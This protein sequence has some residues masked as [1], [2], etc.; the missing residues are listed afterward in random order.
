MWEMKY[1]APNG[2]IDFMWYGSN[3]TRE[4]AEQR[5]RSMPDIGLEP[6][7]F[8]KI[9]QL[10]TD[11]EYLTMCSKAREESGRYQVITYSQGNGV[12]EKR[13]YASAEKAALV[14]RGYVNG[15]DPLNSGPIYDAA[16]VYDSKE[17]CAAKAYWNDPRGLANNKECGSLSMMCTNSGTLDLCCPDWKKKL[18]GHFR[19]ALAKQLQHQHIRSSG[20][21]LE[22][23]ES[24]NTCNNLNRELIAAMA[25]IYGCVY[26]GNVNYYDEQRKHICAGT[27]SV[28]E[29]YIGQKILNFH[30]S[31]AVPVKDDLLEEM[32]RDW[33]NGRQPIGVK[34]VEQITKRVDELGSEH[35]IWF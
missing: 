6:I 34:S 5:F 4:E 10:P 16:I 11:R 13:K 22:V 2:S 20:G 29:E 24:D 3:V 30:C 15:A 32:I 9:S 17:K 31:F 7:S 35:F 21:W 14:A 18:E 23:R 1:A 27:E 19:F 25:Q 12:N 8:R 26:L 33:N 28:Y